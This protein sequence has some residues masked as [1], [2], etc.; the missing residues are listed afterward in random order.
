MV[1]S[2]KFKVQSSKRNFVRVEPWTLGPPP[3]RMSL[4][5]AFG[6]T[7]AGWVLLGGVFGYAYVRY[8]ESVRRGEISKLRAAQ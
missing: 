6:S 7:E 4:L 2:S 8:K 1:Q 5:A 3:S